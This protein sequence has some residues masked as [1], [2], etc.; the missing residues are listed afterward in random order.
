MLSTFQVLTE[1]TQYQLVASNSFLYPDL[2]KNVSVYFAVNH[3]NLPSI[4]MYCNWPTK[5]AATAHTVCGVVTLNVVYLTELA[6]QWWHFTQLNASSHMMGIEL[7]TLLI[8]V[9]L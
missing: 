4:L 1:I 3:S 9:S 8:S 6:A 5:K 7:S 2:E